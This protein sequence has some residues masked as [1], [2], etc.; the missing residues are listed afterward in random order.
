MAVVC[1]QGL[2]VARVGQR[3]A[4]DSAPSMPTH[5]RATRIAGRMPEIADAWQQPTSQSLAREL[6][7]LSANHRIGHRVA[8]LRRGED[9]LATPAR[10]SISLILRE[11]NRPLCV[12]RC[13]LHMKQC[14]SCYLVQARASLSCRS[15]GDTRSAS[16][17]GG[18]N[19]AP[20]ADCDRCRA[21]TGFT[22]RRRSTN[23]RLSPRPR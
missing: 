17:H 15:H 14:E 13:Q 22:R 5:A 4:A 18:T 6:P 10:T 11:R 1:G 2:D 7:W 19:G 23:P 8:L 20:T 9:N 3:S 16:K 21:S 12:G